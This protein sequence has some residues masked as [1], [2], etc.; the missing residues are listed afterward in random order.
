MLAHTLL[1]LLFA[2]GGSA[3]TPEGATPAADGAPAA[4]PAPAPT[5][6]SAAM[7]Q[8]LATRTPEPRCQDVD[9][10][11][12]D[13]IAAYRTILS[14]ETDPPFVPMRAASCLLLLHPREAEA[15]ALAWVVDP[16]ATSLTTLVLGRLDTMPLESAKKVALAAL[17][18]PH[19]E[20]ARLRI[21][22]L[23]TPELKALAGDVVPAADSAPAGAPGVAPAAPPVAAPAPGTP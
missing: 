10:L 14:T 16:K 23:R 8:A 15:D 20:M 17:G 18:G 12:P 2:C 1:A 21:S 6:E 13:P 3:P 22:R 7:L 9:K 4:A 19:A 5:A 11:V